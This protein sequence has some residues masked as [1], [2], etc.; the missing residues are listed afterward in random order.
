MFENL[1]RDALPLDIFINHLGNSVQIVQGQAIFMTSTPKIVPHAM[2]HNL[3]HN[4]ILHEL[5]FL[6]TVETKDVP[7]VEDDARIYIKKLDERFI[8]V[9]VYYGFKDEPDIPKALKQVYD[10]LELEFNMM[11][12]S[13]FISR[14]RVISTV[15]DGMA[16]WREKLFISMQRNTS[17][18]SDFYQIPSNRVVE[19][20]SQI[21]I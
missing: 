13:F 15:G 20:G 17:A 19:L 6:I 11:Q 5:N 12:I 4:K 14:D 2:L 16:P 1:Q 21:E 9:I 3:K 10:V 7:Y 18:V 8:K